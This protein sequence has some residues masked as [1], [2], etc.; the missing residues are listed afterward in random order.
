MHDPD[1]MQLLRGLAKGLARSG[2]DAA[3][4]AASLGNA[5]LPGDPLDGL[6][7]SLADSRAEA[8]RFYDGGTG[9]HPLAES[10]GQAAGGLALTGAASGGAVRSLSALRRASDARKAAALLRPPSTPGRYTPLDP[11]EYLRPR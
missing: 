9:A 10:V 4:G 5:V 11:L 1:I 7:A 6:R 8:D 3:D 2:Y